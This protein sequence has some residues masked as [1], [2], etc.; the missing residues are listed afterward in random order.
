M[1][2]VGMHYDVLPGKEAAFEDAQRGVVAQLRNAVG[3][4]RTRL[5]RDVDRPGSYLIYSEWANREAF[6]AFTHSTAFAEVTR[7]GREEILSGPPQHHIL[8]EG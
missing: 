5:Y 4:T 3:H 7:R 8:T 6:M 2:T 1:V